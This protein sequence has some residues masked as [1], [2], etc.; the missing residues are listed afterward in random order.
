MLSDD[1]NSI[2]TVA[3][4]GSRT[5]VVNSAADQ[6]WFGINLVAGQSY[7]FDATGSTLS[8]PTLALRNAAG[9]QLAFSDD[10][11]PGLNSRIEFTAATSGTYF[12]DVGGFSSATGSYTLSARID[13]VPQD[14]NTGDF[15]GN[16]GDFNGD[17][18]ADILWQNDNG[19]AAIWLMNGTD[20]RSARPAGGNPGPSWHVKDAGDFNADGKADI[21]WQNDN[22]QAAIWLMNGATPS[23]SPRSAAIPARRGT[24]RLPPTSTAMARPTS[25]GRTTMGRPRSG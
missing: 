10:G 17:G 2:D 20:H 8:D 6:D 4:G 7:I 12:L 16:T 13:D 21:L 22:G 1:N 19:Q 3:V 25:C 14:F 24:R 18:K 5:G 9:T 15:N 11:G 23:A